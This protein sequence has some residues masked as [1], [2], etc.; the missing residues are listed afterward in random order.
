MRHLK[1]IIF[2]I[3][4]LVIQLLS[5]QS[6]H[7]FNCYSVLVG[8]D[9]TVDG[10]VMFAHNED[11]YGDQIVNMYKVPRINHK[12][13]EVV[14]LKNGGRIP[15]VPTTCSYIWLNMPGMN[16]SDSYLNEYGV[17]IASNSCP[18]KE[19]T[20]SL[21]NGG[22]GY[23]LRRIMAERAKTSREA[24][25]IAGKL[26]EEFGYNHSGRTYC[27]ADPNEAWVLSVVMGKNWIAQRVPD[28]KIMVLPNYYT[29]QNIDLKDTIN[30]LSSPN[31]IKIAIK[32]GWYSPNEDG[33]F[34]FR[35]VYGRK[36]SLEHPNNIQRKWGGFKL[37]AKGKFELDDNFPFLITPSKKISVSDLTR[38]LRYHYEGTSLENKDFSKTIHE[39]KNGTIC[40]QSTQ[41]GF[42]AQLNSKMPKDIGNVLWYSSTHP[43]ANP[44]VP[45]FYSI[46]KFP[47][48]FHYGDYKSAI[49][50]HF[51]IE[52]SEI[53]QNMATH[54]FFSITEKNF[55]IDE[56]YYGEIDR[57][58]K[59]IGILE[60]KMFNKHAGFLDKMKKLSKE[61]P[62]KAIKIASKYS[63][64]NLDLLKTFHK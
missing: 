32:K 11:D 3:V 62:A 21:K 27:I 35:Q 37:L 18:S 64:K 56:N 30:F 22:I 46:N 23:W 40:T 12:A 14:I 39:Q 16:F 63:R 34:D 8:K 38:V 6:N 45:I 4:F 36:T 55:K 44:F 29:I 28:D 10:S 33:E 7:E 5:A 58:K 60:K 53:R 19:K 31:L 57:I 48:D 61:K 26:I 59:E 47:D 20:A 43:C 41:Y 50:N 52:P 17:T 51:S 54:A 49:E 9:C 42:I 1:K 15:Q 2:S 24:V 25:Q 13:D